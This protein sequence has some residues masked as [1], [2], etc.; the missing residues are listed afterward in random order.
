MAA[1]GTW[2]SISAFL[3]SISHIIV[4]TAYWRVKMSLESVNS[5]P[6]IPNEPNL[7]DSPKGSGMSLVVNIV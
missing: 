3:S 7:G 5:L 6:I 1:A 4:P 2:E